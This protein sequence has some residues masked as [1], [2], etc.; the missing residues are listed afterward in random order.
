MMI[1][2]A[3]AS[4]SS[5]KRRFAAA[6]AATYVG[7]CRTARHSLATPNGSTCPDC[8]QI[9]NSSSITKL[10]ASTCACKRCNSL[11]IAVALP[12]NVPDFIVHGAMALPM[13]KTAFCL[14][15]RFSEALEGFQ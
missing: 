12:V 13:T 15:G 11:L 1:T 9:R 4:S 8:T 7:L 6:S 5:A 3:Q 14:E 2:S 10:C